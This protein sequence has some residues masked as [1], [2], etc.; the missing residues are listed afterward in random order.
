MFILQHS[1]LSSRN[2]WAIY[3]VFLYILK[4]V[5]IQLWK[6]KDKLSKD[7]FPFCNTFN[8]LGVLWNRENMFFLK[9]ISFSASSHGLRYSMK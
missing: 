7:M 4:W 8:G 9:S 2:A 1:R 5:K 6:I 3:N